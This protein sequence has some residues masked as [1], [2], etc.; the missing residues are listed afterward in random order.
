MNAITATRRTIRREWT[1]F[2]A[3]LI[4]S[5]GLMGASGTRT[6]QD[7][8]SAVSWAA[9]PVES[10][11]NGAAD[12][13][14]SY[15]SALTQIDRLR[16]ENELLK[17][18]NQALQEQLNRMPAISKLGD[19][20]TQIT[21][22]AAGVPY[23]TTPVRVVVRDISDVSQRTLVIDKGSNDGLVA[24]EVV[25]DAGLALVG[26]IQTV[27][28]TVS[29]VLLISDTTSVVVGKEAKSGATG[30]IKGS[31]S[32]QLQMQYVDVAATLT[33]GEPVVTAGESLPGTNDTSPYPPALLIGTI[34][35][36]FTD[37]NTVVKSATIAPA[38]HLTD[39]TF[40][41]VITGYKGGFGPP[42]PLCSAVSPS[43]GSS[44]GAG[45]SA[46][47]ASPCRSG[48]SSIPS[49]KPAKPTATPY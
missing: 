9:S 43:P 8:Q 15:W 5:V 3:L 27:Y 11:L 16:T 6:A 47:P 21:A 45:S 4:I 19:D 7:L 32:G 17:Q 49:V 28:A 40:L 13:A 39:A 42:L 18:Q 34:T 31:V 48:S 14:G 23:S 20:W 25:V 35:D 37:P 24:G 44:G 38:A 29:S 26:R 2:G 36:V 41:L 30:P 22:A 1:A 12:T 33:T 46:G 10:F